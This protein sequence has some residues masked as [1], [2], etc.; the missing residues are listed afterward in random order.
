MNTVNNLNQQVE[1][2]RSRFMSELQKK[3]YI[4]IQE[5]PVI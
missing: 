5:M 4:D 1:K 3:S 2:N